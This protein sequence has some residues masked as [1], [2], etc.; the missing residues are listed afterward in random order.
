MTA[1]SDP[2]SASA[3]ALSEAALPE[4]A[5]LGVTLCTLDKAQVAGWIE[6][7]PPDAPFA[8][9]VTPNAQHFVLLDRKADARFSAAYDGAVMRLCDSQVARGFARLLFGLDLPLVAG[10]DLTAWLFEHTVKP[11]DAITVIGGSDELARRLRDD[12]GLT[13]LAMHVPP[14]GFIRDPAAVAACV[15]FV[16]DNPARYV[17]FAVGSPQSEILASEVARAPGVTGFGL[18][19]GGSLLFITGLSRRAPE[20]WRRMGL[21]WLY[22]LLANP[23][24]HAKRVFVDSLPLLP[25]I[26]R[27]AVARRRGGARKE[28]GSEER[29]G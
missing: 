22:R 10:S 14:M 17:F 21:E 1:V 25:I 4:V 3:A 5:F 8:Y 13:R 11:D 24:G 20:V 19:I 28:G 2:A 16:Q 9:F 6:A 12:F 18:C 15:R 29:D 7:R 26:A 27:E 23:R